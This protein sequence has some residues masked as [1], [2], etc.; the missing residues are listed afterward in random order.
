[1]LFL[2]GLAFAQTDT[3][4][5]NTEEL[6]FDD[7]GDVDNKN[8][9]TFCTQKVNYLSPTKLISIGYESQ[10]PFHLSS[11][12]ATKSLLSSTHVNSFG[13]IRLG[14]NTPVISRSNFIFNLRLNFWNTSAK[15]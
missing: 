15:L 6:N 13:G 5:T 1:M 4:K 9:R 14:L 3:T 12:N 8:I 7:F 10:L 2:N 11:E